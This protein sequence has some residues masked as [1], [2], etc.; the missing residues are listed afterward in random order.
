MSDYDTLTSS[1]D[2]GTPVELF[3]FRYGSDPAAVALYTDADT[4]IVSGDAAYE[5]VPIE[6]DRLSSSGT[7]DRVELKVTVPASSRIA[8]VFSVF[9]PGQVVTL[10]IWAGDAGDPEAVY[11]V[12]WTGRV[13]HSARGT[14][15]R[16]GMRKT[17]LTCVP[18]STSTRRTGLRRHYQLSCGHVLYDGLTCRADKTAAT[19][20]TTA[21]TR[22]T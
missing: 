18:A 9:P 22:A 5:A 7:L 11:R 10:R 21:S 1:V 2:R 15:D 4:D 14:S 6:R 8:Q 19:R 13:Q 17:E 20:A 3:E 16:D 12:I